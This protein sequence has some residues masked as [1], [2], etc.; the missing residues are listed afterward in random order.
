MAGDVEVGFVHHRDR[1][2]ARVV[3]Q[4]LDRRRLHVVDERIRDPSPPVRSL[5]E[6]VDARR[7]HQDRD[8]ARDPDDERE[9]RAR[10][11][12]RA[13]PAARLDAKREPRTTSGDAP[14]PVSHAAAA[15]GR[16]AARD[17]A[18]GRAHE[19]GHGQQTQRDRQ[20]P[21]REDY[22]VGTPAGVRLLTADAPCG[23]EIAPPRSR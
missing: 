9:E 8:H 22:H 12:Q 16:R 5:D 23:T 4:A 10:T 20:P 21:D 19:R 11:G 6:I 3:D 14:V 1:G 18:A 15:L 17:P 13:A 7:P 2:R